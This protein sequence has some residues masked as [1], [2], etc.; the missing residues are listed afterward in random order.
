MNC[1]IHEEITRQMNKFNENF[2][3]TQKNEENHLNKRKIEVMG[4]VC[5]AVA[6]ALK[7]DYEKNEEALQKLKDM[8]VMLSKIGLGEKESE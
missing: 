6:K 3:E 4:D 8:L 1:K 5:L 7:P 2:L